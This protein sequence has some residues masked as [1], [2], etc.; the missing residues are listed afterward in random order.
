[1]IFDK[2][3]DFVDLVEVNL[4]SP[5]TQLILGAGF[6]QLFIFQFDYANQRMRAITRDSLDLEKQKNVESKRNPRGGSPI[7]KVRL[8]DEIDVWL[9]MDTGSGGGV[10]VDRAF[11]RKHKWLDQYST[12]DGFSFGA[13]SSS[14]MQR[15]NLPG[16]TFGGFE[17][18]NPIVSIPIEGETIAVFEKQTYAGSRI[19]QHPEAQGVLGYDVLRHFVVTVDFRGGHVHIEPGINS[20]QDN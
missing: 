19:Q 11:A 4:R 17:I 7:V 3:V 2:E 8:N 5:K 18:E 1:M 20:G 12:V 16:L 14:R 13:N 10:L 6:L 9:V 15:F